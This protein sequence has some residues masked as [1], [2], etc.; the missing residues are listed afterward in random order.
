MYLPERWPMAT[1][2]K[3]AHDEL[4]RSRIR[5]AWIINRMQD[6]LAGK[7][8]LTPTQVRCGEILL[9]KVIPD[10]AQVEWHGEQV[11]RFVEAPQVLSQE[12][13]LAT[14]GQGYAALGQR[15][16]PND[17]VVKSGVVDAVPADLVDITPKN[18]KLN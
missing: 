4:T 8:E 16:L 9:R 14:R 10:L 6:H 3:L 5:G 18:G 11:H 7:I 1:R 12:E 15:A 13:W 2:R 17:A